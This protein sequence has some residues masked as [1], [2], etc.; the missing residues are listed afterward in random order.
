MTAMGGKA[1]ACGVVG[2]GLCVSMA[3]EFSGRLS[4][5]LGLEGGEFCWIR[6]YA[7]CMKTNAPDGVL[8]G[9][10]AGLLLVVA[11]LWMGIWVVMAGLALW[12]IAAIWTARDFVRWFFGR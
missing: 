6:R 7:P 3:I 10:L 8:L 1:D 11:G 4:R 5:M 2:E 9:I 12:V